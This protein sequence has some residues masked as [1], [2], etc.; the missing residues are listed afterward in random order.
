[1]IQSLKEAVSM[2]GELESMNNIKERRAHIS[3]CRCTGG[4][5]FPRF[6]CLGSTCQLSTVSVLYVHL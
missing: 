4:A 3:T 2:F 1:M 6:E 5:V